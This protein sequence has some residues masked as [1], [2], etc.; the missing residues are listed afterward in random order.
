MTEDLKVGEKIKLLRE[1]M[2]LSLS[3]LADRSGFSTAIISQ[4]EN[5][6]IS[7]PLGTIIKLSKA[8]EVQPGYFFKEKPTS[9]YVIVRE[10]DRKE[11]SRVASK[12]GVSY[13]YSYESLGADKKDRKM[14]PFVVTLE[15]G[16]VKKVK[17]STHDGE[18]FIFVLEG[19]MEVTLGD[20]SDIL[21][22]GD[23]IYYDST[24]PH[25]VTAVGETPTKILAVLFTGEK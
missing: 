23:S 13:G 6:M 14:E 12:E 19:E 10:D 17:Q 9:P 7:P 20:H 21:S 5:H 11:V 8:L 4:I 1:K 22:P 3:D 2:N 24:I 25:K 15:P 18:E 16:T